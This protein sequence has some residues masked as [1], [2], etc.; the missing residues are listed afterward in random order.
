MQSS[1]EVKQ[2]TLEKWNTFCNLRT[3]LLH[4]QFMY[5][6]LQTKIEEQN[7]NLHYH[8]KDRLIQIYQLHQEH[9]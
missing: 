5:A 7:D 8:H 4:L 1:H 9:K 3:N 6:Q 2:Q